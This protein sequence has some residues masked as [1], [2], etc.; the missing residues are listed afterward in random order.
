MASLSEP[1]LVSVSEFESAQASAQ[2]SALLFQR[3]VPLLGQASELLF[4]ELV[5]LSAQRSALA[6]LWVRSLEPL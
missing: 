3:L 4:Q 6:S 2:A 5:Q 1:Q